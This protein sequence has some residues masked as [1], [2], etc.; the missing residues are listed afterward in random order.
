MI[1]VSDVISP[2]GF[3]SLKG[4]N[5]SVLVTLLNGDT[6]LKKVV[7]L[8]DTEKGTEFT[9][10]SLSEVEEAYGVV[11]VGN[12][13]LFVFI[14]DDAWKALDYIEDITETRY[15]YIDIFG[16]SAYESRLVNLI[17][18]YGFLAFQTGKYVGI[19][20]ANFRSGD[21]CGSI[22]VQQ[23]RSRFTYGVTAYDFLFSLYT[24]FPELLKHDE[25]VVCNTEPNYQG[26]TTKITFK[27]SPKL[28]SFVT[29]NIVLK[30][31]E[32][33]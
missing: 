2:N 1:V 23:H 21:A 12:S 28:R 10:S 22:L 15:D 16:V 9:V 30:Q 33:S 13:L 20:S 6:H 11:K 18:S 27:V 24:N 14:S 4:S 19:T 8:R 25:I 3:H 7:V 31:R 29:K 32:R 5:L 17:N 26:I